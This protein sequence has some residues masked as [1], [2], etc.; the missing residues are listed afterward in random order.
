MRNIFHFT[1][2]NL[3]FLYSTLIAF[4]LTPSPC[5]GQINVAVNHATFTYKMER[6]LEKVQ[7][8]IKKKRE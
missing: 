6:L 5:H 4:S 3:L 1:K 7:E 8:E 2:F